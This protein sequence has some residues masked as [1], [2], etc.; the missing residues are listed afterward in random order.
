MQVHVKLY[1]R[2]REALPGEARGRA[3]IDMPQGTTLDHLL[4]HL[5]IAGRIKL[6]TVN[7]R[8]EADRGRV[9]QDGDAVHIFPVVVGG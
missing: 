5:G 1:S 9:L 4:D 3:T 8:A 6:I 7:G 2:F